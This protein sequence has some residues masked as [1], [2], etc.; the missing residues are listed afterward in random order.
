MKTVDYIV[1]FDKGVR[2]RHSHRSEKG[3]IIQFVVQLEVQIEDE[4]KPV[5]RYDCSHDFAHVDRYDPRGTK[6]KTPLP[7]N[8]NEALVLADEDIKDNWQKYME[9]FLKRR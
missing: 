4:W 7:L 3:R 9:D 6:T 8:F 5:I 1:L 2:K